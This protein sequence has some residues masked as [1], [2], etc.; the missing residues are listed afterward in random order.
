MSIPIVKEE[1]EGMIVGC[2]IV[3]HG[4]NGMDVYD[5]VANLPFGFANE[6]C[7]TYD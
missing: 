3:N 2:R 7:L 1:V 5:Y 6:Y 4:W